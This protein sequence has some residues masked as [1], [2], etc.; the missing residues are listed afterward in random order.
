MLTENALRCAQNKEF[1]ESLAQDSS[2]QIAQPGKLYMPYEK[3]WYKCQ[4]ITIS[5]IEGNQCSK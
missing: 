4:N 2:H 3:M 1:L 5:D